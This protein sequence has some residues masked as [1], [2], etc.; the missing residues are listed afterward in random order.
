[1]PKRRW[2]RWVM[3]DWNCCRCRRA[4]LVRSVADQAFAMVLAYCWPSVA[5]AVLR[6]LHQKWPCWTWADQTAFRDTE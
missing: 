4:H 3:H 5:A 2:L 6:L 1:M